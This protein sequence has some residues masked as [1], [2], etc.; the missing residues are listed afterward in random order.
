MLFR[1]VKQVLVPD[2][3]GKNLNEVESVISLQDTEI[4]IVGQQFSQSFP[5]GAVIEQYPTPNNFINHNESVSIV[6]SQGY[7]VGMKVDT[8]APSLFFNYEG[9]G[10]CSI[11][12]SLLSDWKPQDVSIYFID[13]DKKKDKLYSDVHFPNDKLTLEFRLK[14]GGRIQVFFN[15]DLALDRIVKITPKPVIQLENE[16]TTTLGG[17]LSSSER[18]DSSVD[19]SELS[20]DTLNKS[21]SSF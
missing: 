14:I 2:I 10:Q 19:D 17:K 18:D 11:S 4:K 1:S 16:E 12:F 6:V 21:D 15:D 5:E 7:P 3:I 20:D 9:F 8:V 13:K